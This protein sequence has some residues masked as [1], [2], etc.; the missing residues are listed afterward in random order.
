MSKLIFKNKSDEYIKKELIDC[1]SYLSALYDALEHLPVKSLLGRM[2]TL[3]SI[4]ATRE[5]IEMLESEQ[6][7]RGLREAD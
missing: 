3:A 4:K 1:Y 2:G 5:K 6:K 7:R